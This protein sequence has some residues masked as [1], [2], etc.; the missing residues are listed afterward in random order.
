MLSI[1]T[2][3]TFCCLVR[4]NN[5]QLIYISGDKL[6]DEEV[7]MLI[8]GLEDAQGN[9]N[10]EG[11]YV[12]YLFPWRWSWLYESCG[13]TVMRSYNSESM[14]GKVKNANLQELLYF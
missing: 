14:V 13:L 4:V 2:S 12:T 5:N 8:Q 6:T 7:D 11:K 3:L 10:Y 1:W 9:I